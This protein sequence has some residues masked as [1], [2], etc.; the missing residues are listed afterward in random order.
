V[1]L[2]HGNDLAHA[3]ERVGEERVLSDEIPDTVRRHSA[4]AGIVCQSKETSDVASGR[5]FEQ[6]LDR[7]EQSITERV[8]E[9]TEGRGGGIV[10]AGY[11]EPSDG[12]NRSQQTDETVCASEDL[13]GGERRI[14]ALP[15]HVRIGDQPTQVRVSI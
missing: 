15:E 9:G 12:R 6:I 2:G 8:S 7:K 1:V 5:R 11:R 10:T 3:R 14:P 4:D 13:L